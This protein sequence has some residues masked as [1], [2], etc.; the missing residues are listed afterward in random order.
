MAEKNLKKVGVGLILIAL[1]VVS[2][3]GV[4][5]FLEVKPELAKRDQ[6]KSQKLEASKQKLQ[7]RAT[8]IQ[9]TQAG[10][11]DLNA[12]VKQAEAMYGPE[13]KNRKEGVLWVD[14][15]TSQF[16]VTL[17]ALNGLLPGKYLT[18]YDGPT[19][20]GQVAVD[21]P[22]DVISYVHPL[23][24]STDFSQGDYYRVVME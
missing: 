18:V 24:T 19:R 9:K 8:A 7:E 4:F 6:S 17:G 11:I 2:L 12:L 14:R 23:E 21:T 22:L 3:V 13:E 10:D 15:S 5:Y 1:A 16:V 20:I